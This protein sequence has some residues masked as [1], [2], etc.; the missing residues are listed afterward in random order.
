MFR[1][2]VEREKF[3]YR[4]FKSQKI[5]TRSC[6]CLIF[7]VRLMLARIAERNFDVI[8]KSNSEQT[9]I[10]A[11][12]FS[13]F[14]CFRNKFK[15]ICRLREQGRVSEKLLFRQEREKLFKSNLYAV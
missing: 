5:A 10:V 9:S 1:S 15:N 11:G 7:D 4:F 2:V 6:S 8:A 13:A 3:V 12:A 14:S